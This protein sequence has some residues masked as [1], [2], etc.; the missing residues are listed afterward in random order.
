MKTSRYAT[1]RQKACTRC[2]A[3]KAKCD[4][5]TQGCARCAL[6]GLP[7]SHA[8]SISRSPITAQDPIEGTA[9][10]LSC[11]DNAAAASPPAVALMPNG[12]RIATDASSTS[13][14]GDCP[15]VPG[16]GSRSVRSQPV[17]HET[18]SSDAGFA[19]QILDH[20]SPHNDVYCPVDAEAI[21][22][23][24][25]NL[26]L[27]VPGQK[28]KEYSPSI[29]A[30]IFRILKAYAAVVTRGDGVPPFVHSTQL[31]LSSTSPPLA[32][33][34]MLARMCE[35]PLP[36]T[37]GAA[38]EILQCEMS[39]LLHEHDDHDAQGS[40]ATFQ[41]YL[42][43]SML[44]FFHLGQAQSPVLREAMM[45]LQ[46]LACA[47]ARQGL[48]CILESE[49]A[50]PQWESWSLVEAKRRTMY[51]MYL[52]DGVL[53][54]HD[55]LPTALGSELTGLPAPSSKHVW[56][57]QTRDA[58]KVAYNTYL[59]DPMRGLRIDELWPIPDG[60]DG[61]SVARRRARVDRWLQEVDEYGTMLY[62][63]TSCTH[64]G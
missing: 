2:S 26:Y 1:S 51:T 25:L 56:Q 31:S 34:L 49:H 53:S 23:R 52:F 45:N 6:K 39:R 46:H 10:S 29:N 62:A 14:G 42:L 50:R 9:S 55:G 16:L 41:A 63:V 20:I 30:Y 40:L 61:A 28:A 13:V 59:A 12:S 11:V 27:P 57:A 22:N 7:C 38:V 43:Y 21:R 5:K 18:S 17:A 4:R 8:T 48:M 15:P 60:L 47:T 64:G 19:E 24:W 44:L 36:G 3:A 33:C 58:W 32:T 54:A 35:K 37:E